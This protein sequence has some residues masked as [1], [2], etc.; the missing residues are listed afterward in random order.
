MFKA[1]PHEFVPYGLPN[2][3]KTENRNSTMYT[4]YAKD[5]FIEIYRE[6]WDNKEQMDTAI[7]LVKQAQN[8]FS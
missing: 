2:S 8:A 3:Q 5:I 4:S 7:S 1:K 6:D